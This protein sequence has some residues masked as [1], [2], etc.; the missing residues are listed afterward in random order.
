MLNKLVDKISHIMTMQQGSSVFLKSLVERMMN[1]VHN[2]QFIS[3]D[4][5]KSNILMLTKILPEWILIKNHS[6]GEL[7]K[8]QKNTSTSVSMLK[9]K[10]Q[11]FFSNNVIGQNNLV[12]EEEHD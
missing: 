4:K 1:E 7:L 2:G 6:Q 12:E 8:V 5:I 10:I 9:K 3:K 11:D